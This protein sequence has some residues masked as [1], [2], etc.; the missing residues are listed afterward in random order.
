MVVA[1][2]DAVRTAVACM[3]RTYGVK[4]IEVAARACAFETAARRVP[5]VLLLVADQ[6]L[7]DA[8]A[9]IQ[10]LRADLTTREIP[11][12]V[13]LTASSRVSADALLVAGADKVVFESPDAASLV[14]T[15][16]LLSDVPPHRR[17]VREL[18]RLL[19]PIRERAI[20]EQADPSAIRVRTGQ[21][22]SCLQQFRTSLLA[23]DSTGKCVA[24]NQAACNATGLTRDE[25]LGRPLWA[26]VEAGAGG[27]LRAGWST[28]LVVGAFHGRCAL[29]RRYGAPVAADI[30]ASAHLLP[31]LH[32][33]AVQ[34]T[35]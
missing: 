19:T 8:A 33:A 11:I 32:A 17:A 15:L 23:A 7:K 9:A 26:I 31:D 27:D 14:S 18:R 34:P 5:D 30:Y 13:A 12:V 1:E 3:L 10:Q 24:A 35:I 20:A 16:L 2:A 29:R 25:L 6:H 21:I 28:F 22:G 4:R